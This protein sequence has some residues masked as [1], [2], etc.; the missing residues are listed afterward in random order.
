MVTVREVF[1]AA[2]ALMDELDGPG[3]GMET[4]EYTSRTPSVLATISAEIAVLTGSKVPMPVEDLEDPLLGVPDGF[5]RSAMP[6]G[7]A[8]QLL[9]DE[10]PTSA[11][12]FQQRYEELRDRFLLRAPVLDGSVDNLYG[13]IECGQFAR[14]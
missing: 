1:K 13:G 2:L 3:S 5:A 7:L 14:W 6:Y 4:G 9:V 12:F 8:A 10:N 11:A